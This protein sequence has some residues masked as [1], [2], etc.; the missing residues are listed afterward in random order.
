MEVRYQ[1]MHDRMTGWQWTYLGSA[2][3]AEVSTGQVTFTVR[4]EALATQCTS[5]VP[6]WE[7]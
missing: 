7:V 5:C 2:T 1:S 3:T 6:R 4:V